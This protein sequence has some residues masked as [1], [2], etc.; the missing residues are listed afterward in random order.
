MSLSRWSKRGQTVLLVAGHDPPIDITIYSDVSMN[1]GPQDMN[2]LYCTN[3]KR[4]DRSR[5]Y[6]NLVQVPLTA[7]D[8]VH[9]NRPRL[10]R[11]CAECPLN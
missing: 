4:K 10:M 11:C 3:T 1:P 7:P 9:N 8:I 5:H 2:T 6:S